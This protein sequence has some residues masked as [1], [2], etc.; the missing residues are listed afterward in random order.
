MAVEKTINLNVNTK[1]AQKNVKD[2]E[3][4]VEGVNNEVKETGASTEAMSGTLDKATG[5]AITKFKGLKG[6]LT[7]V[8]KSFKSLRVAIIGTGIGALLIAV[9][10]LG[11]AFTRSEEGQNKFAKI[12]GVIGS[13]TGNLLDLLADLGEKII[14]VFENPKQ[15][16]LDFANLIKENIINR[17]EGLIELIPQ[18]GKAITLLFEGEFSEAGKVA[19]DAVGKVAL[20]V[21]SVTDSVGNAVDAV[22]EFGK[23]VADDAA[24]AAKIADQRAKAE[25]IARALVVERAEAER[26][27]AEIREKAA[28]KEN[29]TAAERIE[30]LKEAGAIS[31]DLANKETEVARIRL[32]AKQVEN[33]LT[34]S[35]K[36]DL[37]E[38]AQLKA[39]LINKETQ[40]LK[41]QK[42]L[43][44]E[45]TT[46]TREANAEAKAAA[47]EQKAI[48]D[49]KAAEEKTRLDAIQKIRDDFKAKQ[50]E[51]EAEEEIEKLALE[52]EKKISELDKLNASE[53]Q[54][55]EVYK[56]YAGL[57]TDLE[58]KENKKK[59]DIEKL[60]KKQILNDASNTFNQI[61][62]LAG[63]DSKVGK[64]MAIASATISG[65]EGVQNAYSTAQKSPITAVF[66]AYPIVQAA[67]AGAVAVKNIAAIKSVDSSGKGQSSV[68]NIASGGGSQAPSFNIVGA[69]E[70]SQLAQAVGSQTQ[71]PV[72]AYVVANDITTAQSLENNIVEGATL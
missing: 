69:T 39:D 14:S 71:E 27:I 37:D 25:K 43:T 11:Q 67:L 60:R 35:N 9:V 30:L 46:A 72:Q 53:E 63:K 21:D 15:A 7:S 49:K 26:K 48:E 38:E 56:Y 41:L 62:Q 28:D 24:K 17:F 68:P 31:E 40:R 61:A 4:S 19:T 12:L 13:V 33:A 29:F 42:A 5:G 66:P 51:K 65:V 10:A 22:K 3:K 59:A 34:K 45:V 47:A 18:L 44:A 8:I 70:T 50:K 20:G 55:L 58:E 6:G 32:E 16:I 57:R 1:G 64:A 2:L 54:K 23:E 52:E 36:A